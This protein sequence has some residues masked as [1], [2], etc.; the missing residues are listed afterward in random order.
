MIQFSILGH[1]FIA[2]SVSSKIDYGKEENWQI[3][4]RGST[5]GFRH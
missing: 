4:T 5:M 2:L 3:G 1:S